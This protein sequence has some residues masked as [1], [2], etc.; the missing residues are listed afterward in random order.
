MAYFQLL[1]YFNAR[2]I[3]EKFLKSNKECL[4][5]CEKGN[6]MMVNS[7]DMVY[8]ISIFKF[9]C[10]LFKI[11]ITLSKYQNDL[12]KDYELAKDYKSPELGPEPEFSQIQIFKKFRLKNGLLRQRNPCGQHNPLL[13][14]ISPLVLVL[15]KTR[16][17]NTFQGSQKSILNVF[18]KRLKNR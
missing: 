8:F 16:L 4:E 17:Q 5:M 13:Q 15:F 3:F 2:F 14:F 12:A 10:I 1:H 18:R 7:N 9:K 11:N 6:Q